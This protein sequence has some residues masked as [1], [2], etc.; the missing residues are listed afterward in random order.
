VRL[1]LILAAA[2]LLSLCCDEGVS[3]SQVRAPGAAV[4]ARSPVSWGGT[5]G[6]TMVAED[7]TY[8]E[9]ALGGARLEDR[10]PM[11]IALHGKLGRPENISLALAGVHTPARLIAPRGAPFGGGFVWWDLHLKDGDPHPFTVAANEAARRMAAFVRQLVRQ[12]PTLGKPV[13]VGFSQGA[14]VAYS[15]SVRDPD[16][17][18]SVFPLSGLLPL[19]LEPAAWPAGAPKPTIHAFHGD[20]DE[21]VPVGLD[22]NSVTRLR[23]LGVPVTLTELPNLTHAIGPLELAALIPE[24]DDALRREAATVAAPAAPH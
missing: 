10:L 22:R 19:G 23:A 24:V 1:P 14:I 13:F 20:Q 9:Q 16:L 12:K 5:A 2:A 18:S 17:T 4:D 15:V 8:Q 6:D 3:S 11:I 21:I 7:M